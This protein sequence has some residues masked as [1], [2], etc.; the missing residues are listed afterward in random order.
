[1]PD[2]WSVTPPA[3]V[4]TATSGAI[5]TCRSDRSGLI[6]YPPSCETSV[7]VPSALVSDQEVTLL[8]SWNLPEGT[9]QVAL[10]FAGRSVQIGWSSDA[11]AKG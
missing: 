5:A 6:A 11:C 2:T 4:L 3:F 8:S 1:M 7:R 10:A 9:V